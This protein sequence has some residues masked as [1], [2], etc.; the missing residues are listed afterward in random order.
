MELIRTYIE[1]GVT[2]LPGSLFCQ[3][4]F[5]C[6]LHSHTLVHAFAVISWDLSKW[7]SHN[8]AQMESPGQR[9]K[10]T[11]KSQSVQ[12]GSPGQRLKSM[13]LVLLSHQNERDFEFEV[14]SKESQFLL[15]DKNSSKFHGDGRGIPPSPT[16]QLFKM[17]SLV[18]TS[19]LS[20]ITPKFSICTLVTRSRIG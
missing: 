12:I 7:K 3:E 9:L 20:R 1:S 14:D 19:A 11:E 15:L 5:D 10:I 18:F 16:Q 13:V 17:T 4:I 8:Q 6:V 2:C